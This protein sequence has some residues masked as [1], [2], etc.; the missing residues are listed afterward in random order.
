MLNIGLDHRVFLSVEVCVCVCLF[1]WLSICLFVCLSVCV[2]VR[3][4]HCSYMNLKQGTLAAGEDN[5]S[6]LESKQ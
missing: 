1:V 3:D 4:M 5:E 6:V 2:S